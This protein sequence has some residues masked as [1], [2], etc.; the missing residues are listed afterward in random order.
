MIIM[1]STPWHIFRWRSVRIIT[2]DL[3]YV[4]DH[5]EGLLVATDIHGV[6]MTLIFLIKS[7]VAPSQSKYIN[8]LNLLDHIIHQVEVGQGR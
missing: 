8:P 6:I 3:A 5:G 2:L 7:Y 1:D 4:A